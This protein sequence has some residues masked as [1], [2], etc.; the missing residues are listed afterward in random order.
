MNPLRCNL[1]TQF[2]LSVAAGWTGLAAQTPGA[3][4]T[5][6]VRITDSSSR[7]VPLAVLT[8][9][10]ATYP[11]W[12]N[13]WVAP[14]RLP[15]GNY[16]ILARAIGYQP[17]TIQVTLAN[18]ESRSISVA[19]KPVVYRLRDLVTR[20]RPWAPSLEDY[21]RRVRVYGGRIVDRRAIDRNGYL[22]TIE[23]VGDVLGVR[24]EHIPPT[25]DLKHGQIE[26]GTTTFQ[27]LG[28][29][30]GKASVYLD[31]R[32]LAASPMAMSAL[33]FQLDI[34]RPSEIELIEVYR[35]Y[36]MIPPVYRDPEAC[37]AVMIWTTAY[38]RSQPAR[39]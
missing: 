17:D 34:V 19:L 38:A 7:G 32:E 5:L 27:S 6:R 3:G 26:G 8:I 4:A 10:N 15:A 31:G 33:E 35:R 20:A 12:S 21:A 11:A 39:P 1:A 2:I 28:T 36:W 16:R 24:L 18:G 37:I 23:H 22:H 30:G 9:S 25:V 13:G 14:I 29:C